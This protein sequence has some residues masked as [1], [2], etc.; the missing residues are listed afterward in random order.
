[1]ERYRRTLPGHSDAVW[2]VAFSPDGKWLASSGADKTINI[3]HA[4]DGTRARTLTG[5]ALNVWSVAFSPDSKWLASG[6]FDK[7]VKIWRPDTGELVRTLTGHS[8]AIVEL[9]FSPDG[10]LLASGGDDSTVRLWNVENGALVRTLSQSPRHVDAVAFS[11]DGQYLATGGHDRGA[12]GELVQNFFPK[13]VGDKQPSVR[14]WRVSDGLLMQELAEH[15][16][17]VHSVQFSADGQLLATGGEDHT[18][19]LWR[20]TRVPH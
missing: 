7:T 1:M 15:S 3:W 5:H 2:S 18:A 19:I 17:D 9:E 16:N 10:K 6:S 4:S 11:P 20:V 13:A 8:E 12:F 14:L